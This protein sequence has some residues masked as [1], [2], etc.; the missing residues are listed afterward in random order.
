M[1]CEKYAL[2]RP[3]ILLLASLCATAALPLLAADPPVPAAATPVG[4]APFSENATIN[5]INLL[6][7]RGLITRKDADKLIK[8]AEDEAAEA[9]AQAAATQLVLAQ[10]AQVEAAEAQIARQQTAV[11]QAEP[12]P[13]PT[14]DDTV[15][16]TYVPEIVKAQ[17]RDEIKQEVMTQARQENWAAPRT[18]PSWVSRFTPFGDIRIRYDGNYYPTG[19]LTGFSSSY[20][21]YN[22]I[23]T[24]STPFDYTAVANPP[25][26]NVD[27][28]RNR[29]R[30]RARLGTAVDL[31][32]NFTAG[33]RL[34][35]GENNSPVTENQ[36]LGAAN[37]AQ[38]GNF[39][40]YAIW[41]DR[42]FLK[43]E[44][45]GQPDKDLAVTVGRFDNPF[46]ATSIIWADDLGFDGAVVQGKYPLDE[47]VTPF[48]AAGAFPVFNTDFNFSTNQPTKF[49]SEDKWL[50]GGQL[51][52]TW[53]ISQDFSL[54]AGSAY[55][56]YQDIE[57]KVSEPF[58]PVT[59]QDAGST[60]DT[61]PAFAQRGNTYIALRNIIPDATF[62]NSG[63]TNQWQYFGLAT[64]FHDFALTTRLDYNHF[65]P[66]QVSLSGE[67]VK[68]LAFNRSAIERNG[69]PRLMG[70]VNN[71]SSDGDA[72]GGGSNA[73]IVNLKL[74]QAAL[75][76]R[77]DWNFGLSYRRVESDSVVDGFCDS[78]FGGGGTNLKGYT[79][80]GNLALSSRVSLG[81]RWMSADAIAGPP[82]KNDTLQFDINGKL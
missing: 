65:E 10:A 50:Y 19:N 29:L 71:N 47:D 49:K 11:A 27:Q 46:F 34:A 48:F 81:L 42:A 39:S 75:E 32:E 1:F 68:N 26:P 63:N 15:R 30:L 28:T 3:S 17:L 44:A 37:S 78:D 74:G 69:P 82:F 40:K 8:Q 77:W 79:F 24:S 12:A 60:D 6:V 53:E 7:E 31:G 59:A 58:I 43:Y 55:Y 66:F 18:L 5:L 16:V 62:N 13:A 52:F 67:Y 21:N 38:G 20:W 56:Y 9:R 25:F 70:P 36:S 33:L 4:Q 41:L 72:F 73:W 45:G 2:C 76:K 35:T 23:N 54:K 14:A 80:G 57:G 64:P 22:A 51:G 61:R